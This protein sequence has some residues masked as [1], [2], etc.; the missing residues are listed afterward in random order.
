MTTKI[1]VSKKITITGAPETIAR[2]IRQRLTF[3]NPSWI[4]NDR[5]G[6]WNGVTPRYL[7]YFEQAPKGALIVPRGFARQLVGAFRQ[8]GAEY[9]CIDRGQQTLQAFLYRFTGF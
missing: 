5:M 3:E 7:Q 8:A 9:G 4:E 1:E 2:A 6:R